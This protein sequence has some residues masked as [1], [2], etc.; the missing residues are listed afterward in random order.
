MNPGTA[1]DGNPSRDP[2]IP[3]NR[4][5]GSGNGTPPQIAIDMMVG[6]AVERLLLH[7]QL[8]PHARGPSGRK[9]VWYAVTFQ[10]ALAEIIAAS[11]ETSGVSRDWAQRLAKHSPEE[12]RSIFFEAVIN[13]EGAVVQFIIDMG[14]DVNWKSGELT[15]VS[16][17]NYDA[18]AL[19]YANYYGHRH[20]CQILVNNGA[21]KRAVDSSGNLMTAGIWRGAEG[22]ATLEELIPN[23]KLDAE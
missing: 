21:N 19:H 12:L 5:E 9:S 11:A 1:Y 6:E 2:G 4:P 7:C 14:G 22:Y 20:V 23:T 8:D 18:P 15:S 16:W 3:P 13:G 10:K 17:A